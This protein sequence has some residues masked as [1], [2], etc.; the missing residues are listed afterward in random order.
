MFYI[1]INEAAT[2]HTWGGM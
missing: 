2:L 1:N